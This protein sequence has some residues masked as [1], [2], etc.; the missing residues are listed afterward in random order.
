MDRLKTGN[1]HTDIGRFFW[2]RWWTRSDL[3]EPVIK[4][5]TGFMWEQQQAVAEWTGRSY[6]L[7]LMWD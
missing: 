5:R 3:K 2:N 7:R 4:L 6:G 1:A